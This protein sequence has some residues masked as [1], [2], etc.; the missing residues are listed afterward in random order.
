LSHDLGAVY[1][2]IASAFLF[3]VLFATQS[4]AIEVGLH[5]SQ[6]YLFENYEDQL[7][8]H[9][10]EKAT[11]SLIVAKEL[12][13]SDGLDLE[14][15]PWIEVDATYLTKPSGIYVSY[16]VVDSGQ[17]VR[18]QSFNKR[19]IPLGLYIKTVTQV[20]GTK[21]YWIDLKNLTLDNAKEVSS[22]VRQ[23]KEDS[24]RT[25]INVESDN[26]DALE[27]LILDLGANNVIN[28][29]LQAGHMENALQIS[30]HYSRLINRPFDPKLRLF[31]WTNGI[32]DSEDVELE[33]SKI[34]R[35]DLDVVLF[36]YPILIKFQEFLKE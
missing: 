32:Q 3:C 16:G 1:H 10:D 23:Y 24:P 26:T 28:W 13:I 6:V 33:Y 9:F 31:S 34:L 25:H 18:F 20:Y 17:L 30:Q 29:F 15:A 12:K 7:E 2:R 35:S 27:Q 21:N 8:Y 11:D 14:N 5:Q 4:W 36:D 22:L 19:L